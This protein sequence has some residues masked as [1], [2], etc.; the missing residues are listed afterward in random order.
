MVPWCVVLY[1]VNCYCLFPRG[2][3]A[4]GHFL[5]IAASFLVTVTCHGDVPGLPQR[6]EP[7]PDQAQVQ[8]HADGRPV[9]GPGGGQRQTCGHHDGHLDL[10]ERLSRAQGNSCYGFLVSVVIDE[11]L[12]GHGQFSQTLS[13]IW[14]SKTPRASTQGPMHC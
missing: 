13:Q 9:E 7:V 4:M 10:P 6:D 1:S 5:W 3:Q 12:T 11:R 2:S 8:Q 14:E